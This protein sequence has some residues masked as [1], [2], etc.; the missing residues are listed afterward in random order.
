MNALMRKIGFWG[1]R[2]VQS[3]KDPTVKLRGGSRIYPGSCF[4]GKNSVGEKTSFSGKMGR[5]SYIGSACIIR[6]NIGRYTCIGSN[7]KVVDAVHPTSVFV[8]INPMF[9]S[10][11]KQNGYTYVKTQKF[12]ERKTVPSEDASVVIGN[13]V[14]IGNDV[15]IMGG[16]KIGDGA[17]IAAGAVVTKDVNDYEIVG[18][19]P[20]KTI[21]KRFDDDQIKALRQIKWW[22]LD[23]KWI[24]ENADKFENIDEFLK[25]FD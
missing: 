18:G 21:K 4:E 13:D 24:E 16:V 17:V 7:V 14:W 9:Y 2:N 11:A 6:A 12:N 1:I 20:A 15:L 22:N 8:S 3:L 5:G 10:T 19:V 25:L 23:E